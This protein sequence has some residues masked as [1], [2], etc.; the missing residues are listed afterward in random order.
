VGYSPLRCPLPQ[1]KNGAIQIRMTPPLVCLLVF[2]T[3][4]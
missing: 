1:K 2:Y 4:K 3:F